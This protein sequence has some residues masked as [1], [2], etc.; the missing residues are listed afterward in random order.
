MK[1]KKVTKH[2]CLKGLLGAIMYQKKDKHRSFRHSKRKALPRYKVQHCALICK[3][4]SLSRVERLSGTFHIPDPEQH[5]KTTLGGSRQIH[6]VQLQWHGRVSQSLPAVTTAPKERGSAFLTLEQE[7][8]CRK[9]T[10]PP[11]TSLYP[12]PKAHQGTGQYL[13]LLRSACHCVESAHKRC[14]GQGCIL[15]PPFAKKQ[16]GGFS[17]QA[18]RGTC[19]LTRPHTQGTKQPAFS[20]QESRT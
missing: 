13:E 10:D 12:K 20:M 19:P 15:N 3:S 16:K 2:P 18:L 11:P 14:Q 8:C 1:L 7:P 9:P 17:I 5:P 6:S 4:I